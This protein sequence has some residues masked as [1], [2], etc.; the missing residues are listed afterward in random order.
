MLFN[1][2]RYFD[3]PPNIINVSISRARDYLFIIMPD[4]NMEN[5]SNLHLV[6][7]VEQLVKDTNAWTE[8]FTPDL[9]MLM[10]GNPNYLESN[11]F[12]TSHQSVNVYGLPEKCYEVMTEDYAVDIQIHRGNQRI[13]SE[14]VNEEELLISYTDGI[15]HG[16]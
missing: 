1:L 3:T 9:E 2:N 8:T 15:V 6:K 10:F 7:R 14:R 11:A 16:Y 12:S 4:D 13:I 5:T